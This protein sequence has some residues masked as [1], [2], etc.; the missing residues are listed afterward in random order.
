MLREA[1]D[2]WHGNFKFAV[3]VE[4]EQD[5]RAGD[6]TGQDQWKS[7]GIGKRGILGG[8]V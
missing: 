7:F 2:T 8:F 4:V 3:A 1:A 5:R 6:R